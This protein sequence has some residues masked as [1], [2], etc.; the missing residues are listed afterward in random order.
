MKITKM[1]S[2]CYLN[3]KISKP[4]ANFSRRQ[5]EA[6]AKKSGIFVMN[7]SRISSF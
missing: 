7:Q 1:L 4:V 5:R 6:E 3:K 2:V